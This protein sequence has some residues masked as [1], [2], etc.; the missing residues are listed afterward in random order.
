MY[1]GNKNKYNN[2]DVITE[3][4]HTN[5]YKQMMYWRLLLFSSRVF[6]IV[7]TILLQYYYISIY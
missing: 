2:D 7:P 5:I 4:A 1:G 6:R 3:N